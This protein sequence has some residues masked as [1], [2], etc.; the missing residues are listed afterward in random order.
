MI[1]T[2]V[3][4][5]SEKGYKLSQERNI[6]IFNIPEN[7]NRVE[8]AKA[9]KE[10][11]EVDAVSVKIAIIKGKAMRF[12][13]K[14]GKVNTGNRANVKKAYVRIAKGQSLPF[15]AAIDEA[16]E[17]D[18]K[19]EAKA[20]APAIEPKR[21]LFGRKN[22]KATNTSAATSKVTRTQAKIGEK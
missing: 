1:K 13:R 3:P 7:M 8:V 22:E 9:V 20:K 11:F 6:Y 4:R 14:G 21:G 12:I 18:A 19:D 5:I 10:Q 2:L 16:I 17:S 15:F